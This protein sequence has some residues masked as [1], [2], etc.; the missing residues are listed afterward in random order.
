MACNR[1]NESLCGIQLRN[2]DVLNVRK[3]TASIAFLAIW[4]LTA[5]WIASCSAEGK[6]RPSYADVP[7][8]AV[9]QGNVQ[10]RVNATGELR[11]T[12]TAM[13]TAPSIAGGTLQIIHLLKAGSMVKAGDPVIDFDPSQQ[14]YNLGQNRSDYQ[15][16]EEAIIKAKDDAA[17]QAAQDQTALLKAQ[18]DI[19]QAELEVSKDELVSAI[20]AQK[21]QLALDE[22]KRALAQ[23]Q[24]DIKS[25]AASGQ[26]TI[27]VDEENAHKAK[28]SMDQAL[29]NIRNMQVRSPING[30]VVIRQ[31]LNASGGFFFGGMTLPDYQQGDQANPGAV[32]A[33]VIDMDSM[34]IAAHVSESDRVN[35]KVGQPV[36]IHV[37]ALP[38]LVLQGTVKNVATTAG[39]FFDAGG[40]SSDV[41][42]ALNRPDKQLRPGFT[43]HVV[44]L[45]DHIQKALWV[46]REAVFEKDGKQIVYA[47][48]AD[49]FE[50]R[51]VQIRYLSEGLAIIDGLKVGTEVAAIDP[52]QKVAG[53]AKPAAAGPT[54]APR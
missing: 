45:G 36:E 32:I 2:L 17:V 10:L 15:Q 43:A 42:I 50:P 9:E 41:S 48:S 27:A 44:I 53:S 52:S 37:D 22:A 46:P 21:N 28:L 25:H 23:L 30:L 1:A 35:V 51:S 40:G 18:F 5:A 4:V 13:M 54:G 20:D 39:D 16:A 12:R 3:T 29:E 33:D 24:Q 11:S 26:A 38:G 34:E 8:A 14:E 19:R 31:N 7:V 47:R 49:G 6:A